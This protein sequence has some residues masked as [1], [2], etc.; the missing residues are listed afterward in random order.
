MNLSKGIKKYE[1][2]QL[3]RKS[4]VEKVMEIAK[5]VLCWQRW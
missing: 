2:D 5:R 3:N 4:R 1:Y